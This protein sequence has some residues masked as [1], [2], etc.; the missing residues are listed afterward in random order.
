MKLDLSN[1]LK[2]EEPPFKSLDEAKE[3]VA[4]YTLNFI[5]IE[6]EGTPKDQ[7]E[8][9]LETWTKI[10]GFA[11]S[12]I[13]VSE[14]Q[15]REIYRRYNFDAMMEGIVEDLIKTLYGFYSLGIIKPD[16][17]P[18]KVLEVA[19]ELVEREKDLI[20][21]ERLNPEA[22]EFIKEYIKKKKG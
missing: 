4:K 9:T 7:W 21:R 6:L 17:K 16:E 14:N 13:K 20:E 2:K 5:N 15:R 10:C 12:L 11:K 1:L 8:K 22:L 19:V 18:Y 3:Y